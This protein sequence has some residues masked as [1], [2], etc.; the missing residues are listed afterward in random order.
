MPLIQE[1]I[2]KVVG[3]FNLLVPIIMLLATLLFLW[4]IFLYLTASD[5]EEQLSKAKTYIIWGIIA[6]F[7]A[8]SVWGLVFVISDTFEIGSPGTPIAP[9]PIY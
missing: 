2:L 6:L 9:G 5:N 8:V 1:L 4:G 3:L 7:V